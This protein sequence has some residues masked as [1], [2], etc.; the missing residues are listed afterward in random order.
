MYYFIIHTINTHT[1]YQTNEATNFKEEILMKFL[2]RMAKFLEYLFDCYNVSVKVQSEGTINSDVNK[3]YIFNVKPK[4]GTKVNSIFGCIPNIKACLECS[5]FES[6]VENEKIYLAVSLDSNNNNSLLPILKSQ[7]LQKTKMQIP[8]ALGYD[9][10]CRPF[11]A[12]LAQMPHIL[13]GGATGMGKSVALQVLILSAI[14]KNPSQK[15]NIIIFDVGAN[16]LDMFD[17]IQHLTH[18]IVKDEITSVYVI[19]EIVKEMEKR[20][21][22]SINELN[23]LPAIILVI[24]EMVSLLRNIEHEKLYQTFT[25]ALTNLL[26]RGR[27]A[28]I[29]IVIGTQDPTKENLKIAS[30][31]ITTRVAFR[32]NNHYSSQA[33]IGRSGA[34]NLKGKGSMAYVSANCPTPKHIQG[35][36]ITIEELEWAISLVKDSKHDLSN[37]FVIP[38]IEVPEMQ[39]DNSYDFDVIVDETQ[40]KELANIIMWTL[41]QQK[42]SANKLADKFRMGNRSYDIMDK[43]CDMNIV[44]EQHSKQ[45]RRV[46]PTCIYDIS[47]D[48]LEFLSKYGYSKETISE[49]IS[50]RTQHK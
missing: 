15:V 39:S 8:V 10:I 7:V 3:R 5:L 33:I 2:K 35:A 6:F 12:D 23:E 4:S 32:C 25:N 14:W 45:P 50:K 38:E 48:V 24:D 22:L 21:K 20:L 13:Y 40:N 17:G 18:P 43:L 42:V 49:T 30:D 34:E 46:I 28:K 11:L 44:S 27:H 1:L 29:H 26:R 16:D 37:K 47:S 41:S 36:Y 19:E 9:V 31:N